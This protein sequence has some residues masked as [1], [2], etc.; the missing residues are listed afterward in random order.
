MYLLSGLNTGSYPNPYFILW[1]PRTFKLFVSTL[2]TPI[3]SACDHSHPP[4]YISNCVFFASIWTRLNMG[5]V[6]LTSSIWY[7]MGI[8]WYTGTP[9]TCAN[10]YIYWWVI[11]SYRM[12]HAPYE[13]L[14]YVSP[15]LWK[16]QIVQGMVYHVPHY[17]AIIT[18]SGMDCYPSKLGFSTH[19]HVGLVTWGSAGN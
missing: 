12:H 19:L 17:I 5:F 18:H 16:V 11:R 14:F 10:I 13:M 1:L 7:L 2:Q 8:L 9:D 15:P 3:V 6:R 4:L